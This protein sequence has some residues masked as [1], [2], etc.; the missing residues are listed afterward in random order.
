MKSSLSHL[1]RLRNVLADRAQLAS[2][3]RLALIEYF[4]DLQLRGLA[5]KVRRIVNA[6]GAFIDGGLRVRAHGARA[7]HGAASAMRGQ[8]LLRRLPLLNPQ[9][10]RSHSVKGVGSFSSAAMSHAGKQ[11]QAD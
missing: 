9:R 6:A 3:T 5:R 2:V 1:S 11:E 10:E 7:V 8:D 4:Q